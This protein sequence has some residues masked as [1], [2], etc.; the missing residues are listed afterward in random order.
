LIFFAAIF[1]DRRNRIAILLCGTILR[2]RALLL[3]SLLEGR[4]VVMP[5]VVAVRPRELAIDVHGAP[6]VFATRRIRI[7]RND[8][9]SNRLDGLSFRR[10]EVLPRSR[11][12]RMWRIACIRFPGQIA[13]NKRSPG[14]RSAEQQ[15]RGACKKVAATNWHHELSRA[16]PMCKSTAAMLFLESG[17]AVIGKERGNVRRFAVC[18]PRNFG[19]TGGLAGCGESARTRSSA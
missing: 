6:G 4:P 18:I 17:T 11:T 16:A 7:R 5:D 1:V 9:I 2:L 10:R 15:K 14:K 8:A 19:R 13:G 3:H 12:H